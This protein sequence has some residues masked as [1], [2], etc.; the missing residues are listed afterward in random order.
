MGPNLQDFHRASNYFAINYPVELSPAIP[1]VGTL[2]RQ[3]HEWGEGEGFVRRY[4]ACDPRGLCIEPS[5]QLP[6]LV[7]V[8]ILFR[9]CV[10]DI[11][12]RDFWFLDKVRVG[13]RAEERSE[14]V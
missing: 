6:K 7:V 1:S 4:S 10:G 9:Y 14:D 11:G 8:S 2:P 5:A 3:V 13:G 12:T